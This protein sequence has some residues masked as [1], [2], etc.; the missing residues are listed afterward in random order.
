MVGD[1]P[2]ATTMTTTMR[3]TDDS[4]QTFHDESHGPS[5]LGAGPS[6]SGPSSSSRPHPAGPPPPTTTRGGQ[7]ELP[8]QARPPP[9]PLP[10]ELVI[11][12]KTNNWLD[13]NGIRPAQL[14][15]LPLPK[16]A[17]YTAVKMAIVNI[18]DPPEY[19]E[20]VTS[21]AHLWAGFARGIT[22]PEMFVRIFGVLRHQMVHDYYL[23]MVLGYIIYRRVAAATAHHFSQD[24]L[25]GLLITLAVF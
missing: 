19:P 18:T 22:V 10:N 24:A 23:N 12:T 17:K 20:E 4:R 7:R 16:G 14:A 5:S 11:K 3:V 1:V 6:W 8:H 2:R 9:P 13:P 25:N 21:Y 15:Y